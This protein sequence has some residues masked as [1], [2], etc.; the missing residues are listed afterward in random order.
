MVYCPEGIITILLYVFVG[1]TKA[2]PEFSMVANMAA[3]LVLLY[4]TYKDK[5]LFAAPLFLFFNSSILYYYG[6]AV[7]DIFFALFIL[8]EIVRRPKIKVKYIH[9]IFIIFCVYSLFVVSAFNKM[10]SIEIILIYLFVIFLLQ[11]VSNQKKW[12]EFAFWYLVGLFAASIYGLSSWT[13]NMALGATRRY[14]LAFTDPNYAGMF[15]SIG[16]YLVY[17]KKNISRILKVSLM[18]AIGIEILLTM[19]S[20]AI[21]CNILVLS[22]LMV[23]KG[24]NIIRNK[25]YSIKLRTIAA[26][27]IFFLM[28]MLAVSYIQKN[29][30]TIIADSVDRFVQKVSNIGS[31]MGDATT[32]RSDIWKEHLLFFENQDSMIKKILGGNFVTDRGVD[33]Q[34]FKIV[35][36]EVY[37]DSLLCF[38]I[39]GTLIY[40]GA[41]IKQLF[42]KW[43]NRHCSDMN[44]QI[45]CIAVIWLVYSFGLSMFPFWGFAFMLFVNPSNE[46]D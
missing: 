25:A 44:R 42:Y 38:G 6:V 12:D 30:D 37:I 29:P 15:L 43:K 2:V 1:M 33:R 17:C 8:N 3:V 27:G 35:S 7:A 13:E 32:G 41:I 9:I 24:I 10:L 21:L 20:T 4:L 22:L 31:G 39:V 40:I 28:G 26:I 19:S 11:H 23:D 14:M 46:G 18:M 36:H 16:F 34:F 45:W 5:L